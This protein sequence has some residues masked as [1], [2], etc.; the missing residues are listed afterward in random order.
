[1]HTYIHNPS[2]DANAGTA[3]AC[4]MSQK[5]MISDQVCVCV[6]VLFLGRALFARAW[7]HAHRINGV[8]LIG[9]VQTQPGGITNA[10]LERRKGRQALRDFGKG[11]ACTS[12]CRTVSAYGVHA[13]APNQ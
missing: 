11:C 5:C 3:G 7:T 9:H 13:C 10:Q 8:A 6:Q 12:E 4:V 1:M 2:S